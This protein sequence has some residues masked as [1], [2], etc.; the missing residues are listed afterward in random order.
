MRFA[1]TLPA[2]T[3]ISP[4]SNSNGRRRRRRKIVRRARRRVRRG[5]NT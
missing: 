2:L 4:D 5:S 3:A 1:H